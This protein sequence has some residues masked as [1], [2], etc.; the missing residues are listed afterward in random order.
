MAAGD[1]TAVGRYWRS[2]GDT[3]LDRLLGEAL[4]ANLDVEAAGA[5]IQGARAARLEATLDFVPTVTA[6]AGY[7]R[8]RI[9]GASFPVG[10][11]SFPAST[12]PGRWTCSAGCGAVSRPAAHWS[13]R[14]RRT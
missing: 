14:R 3:T 9:A 2:L 5:R 13:A 10:S 1:T 11:G 8:Q 7:T 4:R 12:P 6:V